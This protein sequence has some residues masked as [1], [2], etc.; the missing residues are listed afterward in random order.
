[1]KNIILPAIIL[2]QFLL[3]LTNIQAYH[4]NLNPKP[5]TIAIIGSGIGGSSAA[6]YLLKE[7][8]NVKVDIYE[9]SSRIG[10]R[11][12]S[13]T[14]EG[15][16]NDLGASFFIQENELIYSIIKELKIPYKSALDYSQPIAFFRDR[17]I[18]FKSTGWDLIDL[19]KLVWKYGLSPFRMYFSLKNNLKEFIKIYKV[20]SQK[21]ILNGLD[22]FLERI[23]LKN[24][25]NMTIEEFLIKE[26]V[27]Q[28]FID[29]IVS[30]MIG[31]IYNQHKEINAFA[32]FITLAGV[33]YTPYNI[34]GGNGV[35]V[36]K[37]IEHL[38]TTYS[39]DI[40][41]GENFKFYYK[42]ITEI[43]KDSR[44]KF[45]LFSNEEDLG[46]YDY[47]IIACPLLKTGIKFSNIEL[48]DFNKMPQVFQTNKKTLIHAKIDPGYF[49]YENPTTKPKDFLYSLISV[50]K[51]L[52]FNISE[53]LIK[54]SRDKNENENTNKTTAIIHIQSDD[55]LDLEFL[56]HKG[57]LKNGTEKL[58]EYKW[59]F[60][61]PKL[62]AVDSSR[63]LPSFIL[64]DNLFHLNA[65]ELA[66]SC[67]E[68]SII[69]ARN[70]VNMIEKDRNKNVEIH[71]N[72][73][74][75]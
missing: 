39:D 14:V 27:S 52:S 16:I 6:Y 32:G 40:N 43:S 45:T 58:F 61:Y 68:M 57:L 22:D 60:A 2:F 56:V 7:N 42:P 54:I 59:D 28:S 31:G 1:M 19:M 41:A 65:I 11:V 62:E 46:E 10:G 75:L 33:N 12:Y 49:T 74:D 36:Q 66:G 67:M 44:N 69:S 38:N 30:G 9:K 13:E 34:Q 47:V 70:I 8:K 29:D 64:A 5:I 37:I 25:I 23:K 4:E 35:L 55:D 53:F 15:E 24:L 73:Q 48:D 3:L 71:D 72:K 63:K 21:E 18:L 50:N 20:L 26:N 51:T 17:E